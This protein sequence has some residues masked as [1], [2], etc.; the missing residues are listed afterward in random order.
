MTSVRVQWPSGV[1]QTLS[2]PP[3]NTTQQIRENVDDP[4][5]ERDC[6]RALNAAGARVATAVGERLVK[7]V[8]DATAGRLPEGQTATACLASDANGR[9]AALQ[10]RT[11][12]IAARK[13]FKAPS[14]GP[15]S[16]AAVNAAMSGLFH[17]ED[18]FG[19]DVDAA[20]IDAESDP[21]GAA[22]QAV[23]ARGFVKVG[24]TQ[25]RMF[26]ACKTAGLRDRTVSSA[27]E[28]TECYAST[29]G[30]VVTN[31]VADAERQAGIK[32]ATTDLASTLP[33]ACA[34]VARD[35]LFDCLQEQ[36]SCSAC[37]ALNAAD[38]LTKPCH[39]FEDGIATFYCGDR[40]VSAQSIAR[41]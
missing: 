2:N 22:C 29:Q 8:S 11:Q 5:V 17:I 34:G 1:V 25:L 19:P 41:Q 39:R 18:V 13:C 4:R 9:I 14:F 36:T 21:A 27:A 26:N 40:P 32:C 24:R 6:I 30:Q 7:C 33:G 20:I 3:I 31:V 12:A 23:V 16:A 38:R 28:L 37:L 10:A 15:R 35:E